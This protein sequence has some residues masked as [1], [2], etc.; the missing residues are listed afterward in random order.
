MKQ[1]FFF[2]LGIISIIGNNVVAQNTALPPDFPTYQDTGN[3]DKDINAYNQDKDVW[4]KTHQQQYLN[5]QQQEAQIKLIDEK[6]LAA[7]PIDKQKQIL[8]NPDKYKVVNIGTTSPNKEQELIT[9]TDVKQ[10]GQL[11]KHQL[12]KNQLQKASPEKQTFI[13][14]HP[15]WY[16]IVE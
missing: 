10:S 15:E 9:N 8:S 7:M 11:M 3:P 2:L 14:N 16:E 1:V 13:K 5:L 4:V 6:E 12:T